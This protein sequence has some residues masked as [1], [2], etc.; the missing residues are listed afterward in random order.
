MAAFYSLIGGIK[1]IVIILLVI[2]LGGYVWTQKQ[3]ADEA[4]AARDVAIKQRDDVIV[5]RDKAVLAAKTNAETVT[6]LEEEKRDINQALNSLAQARETNRGNTVTREVII[7]NQATVP[8]N[9][10][11]ASPVLVTIIEAVQND[12]VRRRPQ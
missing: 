8:V 5:E 4:I 2:A 10:R 12:R 6:R 11:Q 7:Q 1:G 3:N 9:S